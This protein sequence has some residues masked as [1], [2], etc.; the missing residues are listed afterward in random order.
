[1][2]VFFFEGLV[3]RVD[4]FAFCSVLLMAPLTMEL[5][6]VLLVARLLSF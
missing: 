6:C 4:L 1:M 3:F 5:I 2:T